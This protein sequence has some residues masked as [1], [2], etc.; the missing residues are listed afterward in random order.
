MVNS[1]TSS[2]FDVII[3]GA[4]LAGSLTAYYLKTEKPDLRVALIEA[5]TRVGGNQTWGFRDSDLSPRALDIVK[6]LIDRSWD[7]CR[8]IFPRYERVLKSRYSAIRSSDFHEKVSSLIGSGLRLNCEATVLTDGQVALSNGDTLTAPLVL[9]ARGFSQFNK[10][11]SGYHKFI[12]YDVSFEEPHG[13]EIPVLVDAKCAQLDGYRFFQLLPWSKS[14]LL[15]TEA[16]ESSTPEL[17]H[18]RISRS[19]YSLIERRGWRLTSVDAE[20]SGAFYLPLSNDYIPMSKSGDAL[21]IGVRGGYFHA[22]TGEAF[23][24][25]LRFAEVIRS[26]PEPTTSSVREW[27]HRNRRSW[28]R[29]QWFYR[30]LNR[31]AFVVSEPSERYRLHQKFFELQPEL[32]ERYFAEKTTWADT[33]RISSANPAAPL[34]HVIHALRQSEDP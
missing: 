16:Y 27:L 34:K 11:K 29:R 9:D 25:A 15:V 28:V 1:S 8:V 32:I 33:V 3:A 18:E 4:G 17:N 30:L 6:P 7:D 23:A 26:A 22:G 20:Q 21:P 13:V 14:R 19:L 5:N 2:D 24:D 31:I 10:P 12:S